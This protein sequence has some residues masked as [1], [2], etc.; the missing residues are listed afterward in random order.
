M[1]K[2]R[3]AIWNLDFRPQNECQALFTIQRVAI[4][5]GIALSFES[6]PTC[7]DRTPS[8]WQK[9]ISWLQ[10]EARPCLGPSSLL[11]WWAQHTAVL[12]AKTRGQLGG[13]GVLHYNCEFSQ[14]VGRTNVLLWNFRI[15]ILF[16]RFAR[17][18]RYLLRLSL[19]C[20]NLPS[21]PKAKAIV[22]THVLTKSKSVFKK[23]E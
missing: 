14:T 7:F 5:H 13:C 20:S 12:W 4:N 9:A 18:V 11:L 1:A 21:L 22:F 10:L 2:L 6:N 16:S 17:F 8:S 23:V 3:K 19:K 15:C